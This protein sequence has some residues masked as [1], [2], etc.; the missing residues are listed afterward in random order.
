[1]ERKLNLKETEKIILDLLRENKRMT[2]TE[3]Q[4]VIRSKDL[5]CPDDPVRIL[6]KLKYKGQI[7][8]KFSIKNLGYIWWL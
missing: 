1:M 4:N 8:S 2:T 6:S 3:I 5:K 7:H